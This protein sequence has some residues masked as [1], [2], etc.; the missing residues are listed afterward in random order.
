VTC[1]CFDVGAKTSKRESC[2]NLLHI[3]ADVHEVKR[4]KKFV[5]QDTEEKKTF[6]KNVVS[7]LCDRSNAKPFRYKCLKTIR[8]FSSSNFGSQPGLPDG[9][10][11]NQKYQFG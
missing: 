4:M 6:G 5:V 8:V 7:F 11:S 9:L 3:A 2:E 10:F 1:F